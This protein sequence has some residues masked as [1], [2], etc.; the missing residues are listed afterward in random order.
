MITTLDGAAVL[1]VAELA[2]R[3]AAPQ[4]LTIGGV[5]YTDRDLLPVRSPE[6][7][8]SALR[9][10]TLSG[11][12]T[13]LAENRDHLDLDTLILHVENPARV[14]LR[15]SL[16]GARRQ[17][18]YYA[19]AEAFDRFGAVQGFG[20]GRYLEREHLTVAVQ[21]LFEPGWDRQ[22]VLAVIGNVK[23]GAQVVTTDDGHT[24]QVETRRG[25][26]LIQH[27]YLQASYMLAPYRTFPEIAQPASPYVLR[28]QGGGEVRAALFEADGGAWR[29]V[30]IHAVAE[31]LQENCGDRA[32]PVI[33]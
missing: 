22:E 2:E 12:T 27:E 32:V 10:E 1:A 28:L 30:A 8:P 15:S 9:L 18:M 6:P 19:I 21:A 7:E 14:T 24:Q 16:V 17:R 20:F 13:Y 31:W 29:Q 26:H 33:A 11:L 4:V 5:D 23:D 3:A 25:V